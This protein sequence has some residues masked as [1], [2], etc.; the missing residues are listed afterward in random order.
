MS[1]RKCYI[2]RECRNCQAA[3]GEQVSTELTRAFG[4]LMLWR[5]VS[6]ISRFSIPSLSKKEF[7]I[8]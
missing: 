4:P 8:D 1:G 5:D 2:F 3:S 6:E 7:F